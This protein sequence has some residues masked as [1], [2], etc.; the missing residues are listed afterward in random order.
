MAIKH[1]M[2]EAVTATPLGSP[3]A[4]SYTLKITHGTLQTLKYK[5][6]TNDKVQILHRRF[7]Q[8]LFY[9]AFMT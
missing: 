1:T 8:A 6:K 2:K 7:T 4:T 5:N 3:L 9:D